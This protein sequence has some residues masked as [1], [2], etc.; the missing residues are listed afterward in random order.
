MKIGVVKLSELVSDPDSK[1]EGS[2]NKKD[3][4]GY[5]CPVTNLRSGHV[6]CLCD[7]KWGTYEVALR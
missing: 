7:T 3:N 4:G 1:S 2:F 6:L 5:S